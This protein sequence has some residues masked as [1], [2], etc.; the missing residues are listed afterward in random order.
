VYV[1]PW[2][3]L[4]DWHVLAADGTDIV[5]QFGQNGDR[6]IAADFD[7]DGKHDKA[8]IRSSNNL[9][10]W[11]FHFSRTENAY[12][13]DYQFGLPGDWIF[14]ADMNGDGCDELVVS[15]AINGGIAWVWQSLNEHIPHVIY[16]HGLAGDTPLNP[17]DLDGDGKAD[18]IVG[19]TS[20]GGVDLFYLS[21]LSNEVVQVP[22]GLSG[23][24]PL[25]GQFS[26]VNRNEV[27]V[28]RRGNSSFYV[29]RFNLATT[30]HPLGSSALVLVKP[31]GEVCQPTENKCLV[32][33]SGGGTSPGP[34]PGPG[35]DPRPPLEGCT[36][37][38]DFFDG[39]EGSLWKPFSDNTGNPV[40]LLPG[41]Y[42]YT[43]EDI[44]I[45]D[46]DGQFILNGTPRNCCP[47]GVRAHYD[48]RMNAYRLKNYAPITVVLYQRDG[49][50]E[51]R[52][53]ED[54]T[55]RND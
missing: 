30:E 26:G 38:A 17:D 36:G 45:L 44:E 54:P 41:R 3:A 50:K 31:T 16:P 37:P 29:R 47:N 7:C 2:D 22:Y 21:S 12:L 32:P 52:V 35:H 34:G 18:V 40:F 13:F 19:R 27:S 5:E 20:G 9:L 24:I 51:C 48:V 39:P 42:W 6:P 23:D 4:L 14:A 33:S 10:Y 1:R 53:V 55:K 28:Y 15:R 11:Y 25:T 49:S 46:R 8:V 43:V